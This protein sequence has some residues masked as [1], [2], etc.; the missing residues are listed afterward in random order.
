M[1]ARTFTLH[2]DTDK[3]ACVSYIVRMPVDKPLSVEIREAEDPRTL[4]QNNLSFRWYKEISRQT[5]QTPEE[6]RAYCKL[7]IGVGILK[8]G[9]SN[10]CRA[11]AKQYDNVIKPMPYE[12]KLEAMLPPMEF[13]IT[14]LMSKKLKSRYLDTMQRHFAE[15]GI[16]LTAGDDEYFLA[17][18][19]KK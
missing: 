1:K 9:T 14:S 5:G 19:I 12:R 10:L 13:R 15:Q 6:A 11:F 18:G 4:A 8:S 2:T 17:L 7:H 16:N 3:A